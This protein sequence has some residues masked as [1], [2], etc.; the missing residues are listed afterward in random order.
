MP[1]SEHIIA[2]SAALSHCLSCKV[3]KER[4][5]LIVADC[6]FDGG[7]TLSAKGCTE[8]D[9]PPHMFIRHESFTNRHIMMTF[10]R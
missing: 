9:V 4:W 5:S 7:P 3:S 1:T 10:S 6:D 8:V 2:S